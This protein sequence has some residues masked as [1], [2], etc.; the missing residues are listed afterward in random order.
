MV[1]AGAVRRGAV[2]RA[3]REDEQVWEGKIDSLKR[4]KEDVREVKEGF[5][6]GISLSGFADVKEGDRLEVFEVT[7][8]RQS[9]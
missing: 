5:D 6:C 2:V 7:E 3:F 1:V 4:F 9:L 8:V